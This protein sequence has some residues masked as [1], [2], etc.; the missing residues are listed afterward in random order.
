MSDK[1]VLIF[2]IFSFENVYGIMWLYA[3]IQEDIVSCRWID[4]HDSDWGF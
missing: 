1:T 4:E 3:V 2:F